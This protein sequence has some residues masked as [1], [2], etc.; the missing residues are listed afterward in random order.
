MTVPAPGAL[1]IDARPPSQLA[2]RLMPSSP[3]P[4]PRSRR[5]LRHVAVGRT[6]SR[7]R[8]WS[9]IAR[10]RLLGELHRMVA[11]RAWRTAFDTPLRRPSRTA[12]ARPSLRAGEGARDFA[13]DLGP[14]RQLGEPAPSAWATPSSSRPGGSRLARTARTSPIA[15]CTCSPRCEVA[16]RRCRPGR[17]P[18]STSPAAS[19]NRYALTIDWAAVSWI[20][21]AIRARSM[22]WVRSASRASRSSR[23]WLR[24]SSA[25]CRCDDGRG[26]GTPRWWR[27]SGRARPSRASPVRRPV[28]LADLQARASQAT[29]A[30]ALWRGC[31]AIRS[32]GPRAARR[33]DA[34]VTRTRGDAGR[35]RCRRCD[36][37]HGHLVAR[38]RRCRKRDHPDSRRA[39]SRLGTTTPDHARRELCRT[40]T[41]EPETY[42]G[43]AHRSAERRA[44]FPASHE[45]GLGG[46]AFRPIRFA[47]P[48]GRSGVAPSA[49]PARRRVARPARSRRRAPDRT[50]PGGRE[51]PQ[52]AV[53]AA[54]DGSRPFSGSVS[55]RIRTA[56]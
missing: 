41:A 27:S 47:S 29:G 45:H 55:K 23:R 26:R 12:P 5:A 40:G 28:A 18:R 56:G 2:W 25:R 15:A 7:R 13:P 53:G 50:R 1:R 11:A 48:S 17:R 6:R 31:R 34:A 37:Q 9:T 24:S 49:R 33:S 52:L 3:S 39:G 35:S 20:W 10:L 46:P 43:G 8:G 38:A 36:A 21:W 51:A 22:S 44:V 19:R 16:A 30:S 54:R 14:R 32:L 4:S 42:V